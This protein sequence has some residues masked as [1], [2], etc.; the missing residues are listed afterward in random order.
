MPSRIT[1]VPDSMTRPA[2]I[3]IRHPVNA[4]TD[5]G[6]WRK[7]SLGRV[8][9]EAAVAVI[10]VVSN[11][12]RQNTGLDRAGLSVG[13]GDVNVLLHPLGGKNGRILSIM[14]TL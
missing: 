1:S 7:P 12:E 6:C 5:G 11:R 4:W 3:T 2:A 13:I 9:G 10:A 8:D 14:T